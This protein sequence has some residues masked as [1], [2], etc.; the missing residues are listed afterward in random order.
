MIRNTVV[1]GALALAV[2]CLS[3]A[4]ALAQ[5]HPNPMAPAHT[6]TA[7]TSVL[8]HNPQ[9]TENAHQAPQGLEHF[10]AVGAA[11]CGLEG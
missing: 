3:A 11:M 10:A 1:A 4:P 2:S 8:T 9:T 5:P 7:C 6:G